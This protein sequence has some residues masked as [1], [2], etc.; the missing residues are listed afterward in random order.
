[1]PFIKLFIT[2]VLCMFSILVLSYVGVK[3]RTKDTL[4]MSMLLSIYL[5][6]ICAIIAT[7]FMIFIVAEVMYEMY[8]AKGI[9]YYQ[10]LEAIGNVSSILAGIFGV[11]IYGIFKGG[12]VKNDKKEQR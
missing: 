12:I 6:C 3:H 1:M 7:A 10:C 9:S 2:I 5:S 8:Q 11:G 4:Q